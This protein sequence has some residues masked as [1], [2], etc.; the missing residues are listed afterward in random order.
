MRAERHGRER[1]KRQQM[2]EPRPHWQVDL[3]P[4]FFFLRRHRGKYL[5]YAA[6]MLLSFNI[7]PSVH[8]ARHWSLKITASNR[9]VRNLL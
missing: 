9:D 7:K 1:I 4:F 5:F 8:A 3:H 2:A 6:A